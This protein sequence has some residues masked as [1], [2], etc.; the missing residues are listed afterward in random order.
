M[1]RALKRNNENQPAT[2][3]MRTDINQKELNNSLLNA[4]RQG[5]K[6]EVKSLLNKGA[7]ANAKGSYGETALHICAEQNHTFIAQ[8]LINHWADIDA[9]SSFGLTPLHFA[10]IH[11]QCD[12]VAF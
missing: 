6:E 8:L 11:E 5:D 10:V 12:M 2:K 1:K 3:R 4:V 9:K 7:D